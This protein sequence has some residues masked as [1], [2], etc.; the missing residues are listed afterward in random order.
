R[1]RDRSVG[2]AQRDDGVGVEV[3][4]LSLATVVV[5]ARAAGRD[6]DEAAGRVGRDDAPRV[7]GASLGVAAV[8][9]RR[10]GR[11]AWRDGDRVPAPAL[12]ATSR[13]ERADDAALDVR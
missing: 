6:E 10:G 8:L 13:V 3:A 5:G 11:V 2:G 4:A 9:P 1:P 12:R 7:G